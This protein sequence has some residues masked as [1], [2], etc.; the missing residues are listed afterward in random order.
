MLALLCLILGAT[1]ADYLSTH[2]ANAQGVPLPSG[3][4]GTSYTHPSAISLSNGINS[5]DGGTFKGTISIASGNG[6]HTTDLYTDNDSWLRFNYSFASIYKAGATFYSIQAPAS[7]AFKTFAPTAKW[8]I[9]DD[10]TDYFTGDGTNMVLT[11]MGLAVPTGTGVLIGGTVT[12]SLP[13]CAAG[14][15]GQIMYDTTTNKHVGCDGAVWNNL[16]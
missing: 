12:G 9:G 15:E 13:A 1:L 4:G 16:Y 5:A 14:T 3:G 2:D 11:G 6:I 10:C 7:E 8:C